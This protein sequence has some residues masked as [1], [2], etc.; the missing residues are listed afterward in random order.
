VGGCDTYTRVQ[1]YIAVNNDMSG[2]G[3]LALNGVNLHHGVF[4]GGAAG[5]F[6]GGGAQYQPSPYNAFMPQHQ[7][8]AAP[9]HMHMHSQPTYCKCELT[10]YAR[11]LSPTVQRLHTRRRQ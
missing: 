3:A 11:T 6:A 9:P 5:P 8:M 1:P 2:G 4:A 7:Y 10:V